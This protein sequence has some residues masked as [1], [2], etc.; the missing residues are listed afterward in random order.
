VFNKVGGKTK[1]RWYKC[2]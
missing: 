2:W 1:R